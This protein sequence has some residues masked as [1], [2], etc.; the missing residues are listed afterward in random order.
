MYQQPPPLWLQGGIMPN[1]IGYR[2]G[3]LILCVLCGVPA[4][5]Q[6][7]AKKDPDQKQ[8]AVKSKKPVPKARPK[9]KP[10]PKL[11]LAPSGLPAG[12]TPESIIPAGVVVHVRLN[13]TAKLLNDFNDMVFP[14]VATKFMSGPLRDALKEPNPTLAI[15]GLQASGKAMTLASLTQMFGVDL[16]RPVT[17]SLYPGNPNK[18]FL[19]GIPTTNLA[20]VSGLINNMMPATSIGHV[21]F[22]KGSAYHLQFKFGPVDELFIVCSKDAVYVCGMPG[23]ADELLSAPAASR[24]DRSAFVSTSLKRHAADNVVVILDAG[25]VKPM[26]PDLKRQ[27]SSVPPQTIAEWRQNIVGELGDRELAELNAQIRSNLGVRDV[28]QLMDYVECIG[29]GSYEILFAYLHARMTDFEGITIAGDLG[30]NVQRGRL[31]VYSKAIQAKD[32]SGLIPKDALNKAMAQIPGSHNYLVATGREPVSN[33]SPLFKQIIERVGT[34]MKVKKLP[35]E[36]LEAG[37]AALALYQPSPS[38]ASRSDWTV[39]TRYMPDGKPLNQYA[40]LD[41][42]IHSMMKSTAAPMVNLTVMPMQKP[43]VITEHFKQLA[44]VANQNDAAYRAFLKKLDMQEPFYVRNSRFRSE[45]L[46]GGVTKLISENSYTTKFGFFGYNEHEL[47]N[48][49]F[50]LYRN[51]GAFSFLI[52]GGSDAALLRNIKLKP[53]PAAIT[54]LLGRAPKGANKIEV[55]RVTHLILELA[56]YIMGLESL[57]HKDLEKY[58][59][60]AQKIIDQA[61]G[62]KDL[63][64]PLA[65]LEMPYSVVAIKLRRGQKKIYLTTPLG[66]TYPRPKVMPELVSLLDEY[67]KVADG[68]GGAALYQQVTDGRYE[69]TFDLSF[70]ALAALTRT[71][72]NAVATRYMQDPKGQTRLES[73]FQTDL[74][75]SERW[76]DPTMLS[77]PAWN[78]IFGEEFGFPGEERAPRGFPVERAPRLEKIPIKVRPGKRPAL[79]K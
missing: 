15:L 67:K 51:S 6:D 8:P 50:T 21:R 42:Y 41:D 57:A 19:I 3:L 36:F 37:Q 18:A 45:A 66:V 72:G 77:N 2:S 63:I 71:V 55:L 23:L 24:L 22:A 14:F 68:L 64:G 62:N 9:P 13:G 52:P 70:S 48:R 79:K 54:Q 65:E 56:N 47:I 7:R 46:A 78:P 74:D 29:L 12:A 59:V 27:F 43:A 58:L 20:A 4:M 44:E 76:Q 53:V 73:L 1:W 16:D 11:V 49:R 69:L 31:T 33:L 35:T 28:H 26:L 30:K 17:V 10:R 32:A 39:S 40:G 75:R 25:P 38:L 61:G 60:N 5:A 34:K